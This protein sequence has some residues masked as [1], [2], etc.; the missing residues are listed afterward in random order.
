MDMIDQGRV[1]EVLVNLR[2]DEGRIEDIL[3]SGNFAELRQIRKESS[4]KR[5]PWTSAFVIQSE[6]SEASKRRGVDSVQAITDAHQGEDLVEGVCTKSV[7]GDEI[8]AENEA[9]TIESTGFDAYSKP[10]RGSGIW[11]N[12][13]VWEEENNPQEG[14]GSKQGGRR[15]LNKKRIRRS[16]CGSCDACTREPCGACNFCKK[17]KL[18]NRFVFERF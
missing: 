12:N 4:G 1:E 3:R 6:P 18:K 7:G 2:E 11:G 9:R 8:D 17:P 14:E 15:M 10:K 16:S 5:A 13:R